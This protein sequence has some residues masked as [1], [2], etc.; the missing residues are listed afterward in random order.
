MTAKM[1]TLQYITYICYLVFIAQKSKYWFFI[2]FGKN[3][4]TITLAY[5]KKLGFEV[6]KTEFGIS[7]MNSMLLTIYAIVIVNF[8]I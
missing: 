4:N 5:A 1:E 8:F 7:K 6:Q 2:N 3:F